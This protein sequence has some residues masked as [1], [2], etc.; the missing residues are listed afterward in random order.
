MILLK[1]KD[2]MKRTIDDCTIDVWL[3]NR[4]NILNIEGDDRK[5][6]IGYQDI[7]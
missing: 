4:E 5:V 3:L 2:K 6:K 1:K 7:D